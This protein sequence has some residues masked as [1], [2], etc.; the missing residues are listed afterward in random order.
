[1]AT[2]RQTLDA[3]SSILR[4]L[5]VWLGTLSF[6]AIFPRKNRDTC[7]GMGEVEQLWSLAQLSFTVRF[8]SLCCD[9]LHK[10]RQT[11]EDDKNWVLDRLPTPRQ[12]KFNR[13]S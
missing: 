6:T 13:T 5:S 10:P 9:A 7:V 8:L 4:N 1:M 12:I 3:R 2:K 11:C